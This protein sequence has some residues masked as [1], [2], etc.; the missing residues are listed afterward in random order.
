MYADEKANK[1]EAQ[2]RLKLLIF[3]NYFHSNH[4]LSRAALFFY[5]NVHSDLKI[6]LIRLDYGNTSASVRSHPCRTN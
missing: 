6:I 4:Q 5:L 3:L 1:L 2:L